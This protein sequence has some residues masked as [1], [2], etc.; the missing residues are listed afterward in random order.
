MNLISIIKRPLITE[1]SLAATKDNK[2]TFEVAVRATKDQIKA[3]VKAMFQVDAVN[4]R[5]SVKQPVAK[6]T[7]RRRLPSQTAQ[8]KKAVVEVKPGQT[9]KVFEVKG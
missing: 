6:G 8:T 5:T 4:V 7:G 9:I 2:Y 1:K 3:A